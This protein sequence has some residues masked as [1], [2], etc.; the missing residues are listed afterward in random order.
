VARLAWCSAHAASRSSSM[1]RITCT[2]LGSGGR[3][4]LPPAWPR[5]LEA[6]LE[7]RGFGEKRQQNAGGNKLCI[8]LNNKHKLHKYTKASI[9][10]S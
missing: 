5:V 2:M 10:I 1:S 7:K 4:G 6:I 9:L 8:K 3:G